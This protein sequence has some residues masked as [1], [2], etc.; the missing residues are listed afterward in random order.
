M[1]KEYSY[2][3]RIYP[4]KQQRELI[5][6]TFGCCRYVFNR[7]LSMRSDAYKTE[8]RSMSYE[9]CCEDLTAFKKET[10]WLREPD[11]TALQ[12]ALRALDNAY[13]RFFDG[14]MNGTHVGY[15][16]FKSKRN[17]VQSYKSKN[18]K[19]TIYIT[20]KAIR[21]PKLGEVKCRVSK[22]VAGEILSATVSRSASGKYYVAVCWKDVD[23]APLPMT[24]AAVGV[25]LGIKNL[26][27]TSDG[28]IV[29]NPQNLRKQERK[30]KRLQRR[31]SRKAKG[32]KNRE[33][34]RIKAARCHEAVAHARNDYIN[35]LTTA[36]V[37]EYDII[38]IED[39]NV[40]GMIK[41][42]HLAKSVADASFRE[43][44]RQLEYKTQWYG[45][46]LV[47]IGRFTPSSQTCCRCG[48]KNPAVKNLSIREWVCPH[49]GA[50]HDRD[51]NAALNILKEGLRILFQEYREA[52]A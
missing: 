39:L 22:K 52:S 43:I 14:C 35:K 27:V 26:A 37:R 51:Y 32:S 50:V 28:L 15:P 7:Y 47:A 6:K 40:S 29:P 16:R 3:F 21:L 34:A 33:K 30:L 2:K 13:E 10:A 18:N 44:R 4:N 8:H 46:T 17:P 49:C 42:H 31:L 41:N 20:D 12:S 9:D 25:D 48:E 38:C 24:G 45:K 19:G 5:T 1:G 36:L 11:A 23:I